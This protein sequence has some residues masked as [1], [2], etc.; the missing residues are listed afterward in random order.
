MGIKV[1]GEAPQGYHPGLQR[2]LCPQHHGKEA[3][4]VC[5]IKPRPEGQDEKDRLPETG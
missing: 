4:G 3:G 5:P 2:G 1:I